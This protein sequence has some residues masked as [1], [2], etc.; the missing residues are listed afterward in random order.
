M[1]TDDFLQNTWARLLTN[2][3]DPN[4]KSEIRVAFVDVI[5]TLTAVDVKILDG[6][7]KVN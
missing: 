1:E 2:A 4:F 6:V 3:V 7:V 5:K